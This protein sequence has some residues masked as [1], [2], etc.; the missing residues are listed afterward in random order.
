MSTIFPIAAGTKFQI[1]LRFFRNTSNEIFL[2][3]K[4]TL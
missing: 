2:F 4:E 3:G 1:K